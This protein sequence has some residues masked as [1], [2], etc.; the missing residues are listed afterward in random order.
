M[1]GRLGG[2]FWGA[3]A[4]SL[5]LEKSHF[6]CLEQARRGGA[7]RPGR[8]LARLRGPWLKKSRGQGLGGHCERNPI[9]HLLRPNLQASRRSSRVHSGAED[10]CLRVSL[11]GGTGGRDCAIHGVIIVL[12]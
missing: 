9:E 6:C 1:W 4:G 10:G 2:E 12:V 5:L 11:D 7:L 3:I 8:Q